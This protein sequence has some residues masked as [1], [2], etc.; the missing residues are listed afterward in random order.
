MKL[1]LRRNNAQQA[2]SPNGCS[3][4]SLSKSFTPKSFLSESLSAPTSASDASTPT[5]NGLTSP[6]RT[7][8]PE[9]DFNE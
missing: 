2:T 4:R 9:P 1:N 7:V 5:L 6:H 8:F 3:A